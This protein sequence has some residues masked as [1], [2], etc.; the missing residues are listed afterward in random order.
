MAS[1]T[2]QVRHPKFGLG[3]VIQQFTTSSL[4]RFNHGI[5]ECLN[6]DLI[7]ERSVDEEYNSGITSPEGELILRIQAEA[8]KNINLQWGVFTPNRIHLL[9]HQLW[10]CK[11]VTEQWPCRWVIADDVGLGK[12]VEAG[13]ILWRLM[14]QGLIKRL[15]IMCPAS[16]VTQ[17]QQRMLEMFDI[18]AAQYTSGLDKKDANFWRIYPFVVASFHTLRDDKLDRHDRMLDADPWDLIIV[19]EAHHLNHN[20]STGMTLGYQLIK[21]LD[22]NQKIASLL[23]FTGT[24]HRGKNFGFHA[25]MK[26]VRPDL[27]HPD[28]S[29]KSQRKY[30]R[31]ALIRNNKYSVTDLEGNR[32]FKEPV[33]KSITYYYSVEERNFYDLMTAFIEA[34][35]AY[36]SKMSSTDQKTI[37]L[38]LTALQKLASSSITAILSAL[39]NR[40]K[41]VENQLPLNETKT[42]QDS[43]KSFLDTDDTKADNADEITQLKIRLITN[44]VKHL[45]ELINVGEKI[46]IETKLLTIADYIQKIGDG[47]SVLLFT[48]YKAT[49]R[50]VVQILRSKYGWNNVSFINGENA[51]HGI[52]DGNGN[53]ISEKV[54]RKEVAEQFNKGNIRFLVST[55]AAG[56]G[57]DLH[58]HCHRLIHIDLPWNPMK[59]HQRVGRIN[60]IGQRN[61]VYVTLF[62]NPETVESRI[63]ELLE[64]KTQ[65]ISTALNAVM[66]TPE[67]FSQLVLGISN[68][69]EIER[70]FAEATTIPRDK[71]S[72]WFNNHTKT[73]EDRDAIETVRDLL[74]HAQR[75]DYGKHGAKVPN[76]DIPDLK[77]FLVA[78]LRYHR[79]Q[80]N[81]VDKGISFITPEPWQKN[82]G[83]RSRYDL[84]YF[85]R[86]YKPQTPGLLI[87]IGT[88]LFDA[89]LMETQNWS[90]GYAVSNKITA[91]TTLLFY[92]V[93]DRI[94]DSSATNLPSLVTVKVINEDIELLNEEASFKQ[95][96]YILEAYRPQNLE[97]GDQ[98]ENSFEVIA[99]ADLK[100]QEWLST[101]PNLFKSPD[102]LLL[103]VLRGD[104]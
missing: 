93:F 86:F 87:G 55:E 13:M 89:I 77:P 66:E 40:L 20:E 41:T 63:W 30:L 71:L 51:L 19:D 88:K 12:T 48:E 17:W 73:F 10:V 94:T 21:K 50:S 7:C 32:L 81:V 57:I 34:G 74:G 11:K 64:E 98:N 67:E 28:Q 92:R 23:F 78:T 59:M 8:I 18:R 26:L 97:F 75:F 61:Q 102:Y 90:G 37:N 39:K 15:L 53:R 25:L 101:N 47:S 31:E 29:A 1:I 22:E 45:K 69:Q 62:R 104:N 72:E 80:I 27:F 76:L 49:Q 4:V 54:N 82:F 91:D 100:V 58:H 24:P 33:V 84:V 65:S 52:L 46:V 95:L 38:V 14:Q 70:L 99:K 9:P 35:R 68:P 96:N 16:L 103:G 85:D 5:E 44:E 56:E 6:G 43:F 42:K 36:A 79:K 3:T 2:K 83:V 60:R